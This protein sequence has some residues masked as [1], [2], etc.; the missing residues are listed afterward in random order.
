MAYVAIA[1]ILCFMLWK[2]TRKTALGLGILVAC[3]AVAALLSDFAGR[4]A[5]STMGKIAVSMEQSASCPDDAPLRMTIENGTEE[6][7]Y[8][9][10]VEIRAKKPGHS[11][12]YNYGATPA[13]YPIDLIVAPKERKSLCVKA[14]ALGYGI[15]S[16]DVVYEARV[17][18]LFKKP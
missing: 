5:E 11:D 9:Y 18:L 10:Q 7:L 17:T 8:K 2:W 3:I 16:N 1:L 6:T 4:K 15:S 12:I 13:Y 14:P